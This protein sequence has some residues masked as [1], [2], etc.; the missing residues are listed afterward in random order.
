MLTS[1]KPPEIYWNRNSRIKK[2]EK[3]EDHEEKETSAEI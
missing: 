3:K 2:R 1:R